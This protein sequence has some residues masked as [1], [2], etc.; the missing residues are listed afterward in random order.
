MYKPYIDALVG[1]AQ[2][3]TGLPVAGGSLPPREG[4]AVAA[5]GGSLTRFMD[6]GGAL[7]LSLAVNAKCAD[8]AT[9][10]AELGAVHAA[11]L[12]MPPYDTPAWEMMG[13]SVRSAPTYMGVD[14]GGMHIYTSSIEA[15]IFQRG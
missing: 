8:Q 10:L 2:T 11:L 7:K 4:V 6:G 3:A 1:I 15:R 13:V 12:D 14:A 9:A 5:S